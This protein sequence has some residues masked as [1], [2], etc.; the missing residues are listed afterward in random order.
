MGGGSSL[1]GGRYSQHGCHSQH[2][3]TLTLTRNVYG[4][5]TTRTRPLQY[6][7]VDR[8]SGLRGDVLGNASK[9]VRSYE[10]MYRVS[11]LL[12]TYWR[13]FK[14]N[15][16]L[17]TYAHLYALVEIDWSRLPAR[18]SL[19]CTDAVELQAVHTCCAMLSATCCW[20]IPGCSVDAGPGT[21]QLYLTPSLSVIMR[22]RRG[23][24]SSGSGSNAA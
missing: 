24:D 13:L 10:Q 4:N 23:R 21:L 16:F 8:G 22:T 18:G 11:S 1:W 9:L 3:L 5:V 19:A 14:S 7:D 20:E 12:S 2:G 17:E 6:V 15:C